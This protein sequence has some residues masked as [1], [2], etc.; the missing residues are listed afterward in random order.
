[1]PWV[2]PELRLVCLDIDDTLI[3]FSAAGRRSLAAL[4]GRIDLWPLWER[5]TD[6]HVARVVAGELDYGEMHVRRSQAFLAELG[7][8]VDATDV[9][10]FEARRKE[11][12]RRSWRLFDDVLPCLEWLAAAGVR[13]AAVTNASGAHQREKLAN[14]GLL[15]F[16]DHVAIAGEVGVAKPDPVMFHS[17]CV[18]VGCEPA[19]AVH[20]GDK[21]ETDAVGAR[22][23]GLGGVWLNRGGAAKD[24]PAGVHVVCGL[25]ELPELLVCEFARVGVPLPR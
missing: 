5:I 4:I 2:P 23:A 19:E 3:D 25:A 6:E 24:V 15:G 22:D 21:L 9:L 11:M 14:L 17:V 20:V 18:E 10:Q 1:M 16:F 8:L 13:L 12:L 7:A